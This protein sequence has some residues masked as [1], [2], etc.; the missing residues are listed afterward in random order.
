MA[1][2]KTITTKSG[3]VAENAYH[4]VQN[5]QIAEKNTLF[6][7]LHSYK[8]KDALFS[9]LDEQIFKCDYD[10]NGANPIAQAYVFLK[11]QESMV[12]AKDC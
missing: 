6:F 4:R 8:D 11:T 9:P 10:L 5:V 12:D 1:L 3:L 7:G 2:E